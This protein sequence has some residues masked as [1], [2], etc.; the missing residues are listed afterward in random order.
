MV[1]FIEKFEIP[2][3][4]FYGIEARETTEQP[5]RIWA[6]SFVIGSEVYIGEARRMIVCHAYRQLSLE[7]DDLLSSLEVVN[8]SLRGLLEI[9]PTKLLTFEVNREE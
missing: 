5:Y 9:S 3:I 6:G 7:K 1:T 8:G 2:G 4:E